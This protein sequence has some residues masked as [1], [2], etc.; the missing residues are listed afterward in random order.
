MNMHSAWHEILTLLQ[1]YSLLQPSGCTLYSTKCLECLTMAGTVSGGKQR[2]NLPMTSAGLPVPSR[3]QGTCYQC[4]CRQA[5]RLAWETRPTDCWMH[6]CLFLLSPVRHDNI[7]LWSGLGW[8]DP[9]SL[10]N[11]HLLRCMLTLQAW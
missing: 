8:V 5:G 1:K 11:I 9:G 10:D 6:Q 7:Q 2:Q 3:P 4:A